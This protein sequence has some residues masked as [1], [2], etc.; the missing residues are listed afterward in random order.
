MLWD[1]NLKL[2]ISGR[3]P[4]SS[5]ATC[6]AL[7]GSRLSGGVSKH[8]NPFFKLLSLSLQFTLSPTLTLAKYRDLSDLLRSPMVSL[9]P[10]QM[11][12]IA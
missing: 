1:W 8:F 6:S 7:V 3:T 5:P 2:E 12:F 4:N 11:L 9:V 10:L